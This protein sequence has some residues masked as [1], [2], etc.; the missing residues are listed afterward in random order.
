MFKCAMFYLKSDEHLFKIVKE[1]YEDN[2]F[3]DVTFVTEG[4]TFHGLSSLLFSQ[5]PALAELMWHDCKYGD[6]KIVIIL[7]SVEQNMMEIA[8]M[9]FYMK[10]DPTKLGYI[11]N[12]ID[13]QSQ[14]ILTEMSESHFVDIH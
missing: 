2:T 14:Q 13:V 5:F 3:S 8:L 7:P 6:Q 12:G 11:L 1:L 9:E 4:S 10:G